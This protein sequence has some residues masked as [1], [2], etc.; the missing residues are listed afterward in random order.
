VPPGPSGAGR[1]MNNALGGR[2]GGGQDE[3]R[4]RGREGN[5]PSENT[6]VGSTLA[7]GNKQ[8][9]LPARW[10]C[11]HEMLPTPFYTN[12]L[13][14]LLQFEIYLKSTSN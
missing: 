3:L 6:R 7:L 4:Q 5:A 11:P 14:R 9:R 12:A 10:P 1:G 8:R 2:R 13:R